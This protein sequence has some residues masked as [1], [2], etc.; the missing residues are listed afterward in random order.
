[1]NELIKN[2][3]K[4]HSTELGIKRIKRNLSIEC[5]VIQWCKTK[6]LDKNTQIDRN[7]K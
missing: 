6:I 7:G 2:I 5:D 3:E 4:L 1:M